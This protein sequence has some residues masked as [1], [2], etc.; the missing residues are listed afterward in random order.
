MQLEALKNFI[1][2]VAARLDLDPEEALNDLDKL[3][4]AADAYNSEKRFEDFQNS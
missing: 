3:A 2:K 1:Y 4:E